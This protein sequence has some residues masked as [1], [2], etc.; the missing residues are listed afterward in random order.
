MACLNHRFLAL[1]CGSAAGT[2]ST[3]SVGV[4]RVILL[5]FLGGLLRSLPG[6]LGGEV[7]GGSSWSISCP[8]LRSPIMVE[9]TLTK[10]SSDGAD[11]RAGLYGEWYGDGVRSGDRPIH[12][13]AIVFLVF[14]S[15][16][17]DSTEPTAASTRRQAELR[18]IS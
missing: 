7:V 17:A 3:G 5:A 4:L 15:L 9:A 10:L 11:T 14:G 2:T 12:S 13:V 6:V 8:P 18:P 16:K 1:C